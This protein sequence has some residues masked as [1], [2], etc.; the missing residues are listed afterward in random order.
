MKSLRKEECL[1]TCI[2]LVHPVDIS[3]SHVK[4]D[5]GLCCISKWNIPMITVNRENTHKM[6]DRLILSLN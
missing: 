3:I 5:V 6:Q 1:I 4:V 2:C